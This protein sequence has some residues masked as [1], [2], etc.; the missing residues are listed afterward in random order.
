MFLTKP[1]E[2]LLFEE[3]DDTPPPQD[4]PPKEDPPKEEPPELSVTFEDH[5]KLVSRLQ[6]S[7]E[8]ASVF[9][10]GLKEK[11][12]SDMKAQNK[13]Q[14]IA[15]ME[16]KEKDDA[17]QKL[18]RVN[19][20]VARDKKYTAIKLAAQSSGIRKEALDD[21]DLLEFPEVQI[22]VTS[23][24]NINIVGAQAAVDR[25]KM[26]RA[27][28]FGK[29]PTSLDSSSPEIIE[30]AKIT[31]HQVIDARKKA[32]KTKTPSDYDSY[33]KLHKQFQSQ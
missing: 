23:L 25:L 7:E 4:P 8:R 5:Q 21:L 18:E 22:E 6:K 13:W 24:G 9:E 26:I 20:A 11:E 19:D 15:E 28:W 3:A 29:R 1:F 10:K 31:I 14:E 30:G 12:L 33:E 16:K 2:H 17:V 32:S 27:H